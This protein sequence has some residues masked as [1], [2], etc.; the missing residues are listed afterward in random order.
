MTVTA[1]E[2][3]LFHRP[4]LSNTYF[5]QPGTSKS[6]DCVERVIIGAGLSAKGKVWC[7]QSFVRHTSSVYR[8]SAKLP[9]TMS[10]SCNFALEGPI[11]TKLQCVI[12]LDSADFR[13]PELAYRQAGTCTP[14]S[15]PL[16]DRMYQ[17]NQFLNENSH[18]MALFQHSIPRS[19]IPTDA[20]EE[21]P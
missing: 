16:A 6:D 14:S 21:E 12:A 20:Y 3:G 8:V 1:F 10:S 2:Q 15:K 4:C 18:W 17:N 11:K 7:V 19:S 9:S 5:L 13:L